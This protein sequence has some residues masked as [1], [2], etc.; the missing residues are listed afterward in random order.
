MVG[1]SQPNSLDGCSREIPLIPLAHLLSKIRRVVIIFPV[2]SSV[3]YNLRAE[4]IS[5]TRKDT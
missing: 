2:F 5:K 4:A 1:F 3:S